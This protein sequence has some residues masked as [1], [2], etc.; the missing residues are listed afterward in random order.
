MIGK[1]IPTMFAIGISGCT[2][3]AD[4]PRDFELV[5]AEGD[6]LTILSMTVSG[7]PLDE[8]STLQFRVREAR[9]GE[10]PLMLRPHF[11]SV[12]QH[13]RWVAAGRGRPDPGWVAVVK[14]PNLG[15]PLDIVDAGRATGR[16]AILRLPP[17]MYEFYTWKATE[18][19]PYGALEYGPPGTFSYPFEVKPG[20]ASYLGELNLRLRG[21][22]TYRLTLENSRDRDLA[23]LAGRIPSIR[24]ENVLNQIGTFGP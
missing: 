23:L 18:P 13:A 3:V 14:A 17:G 6:G 12:L 19:K 1:L 15:E 9:R 24:A 11:N 10:A 5:G 4:V 2:T 22:K 8:L 7:K 20:Q 21:E 16:V